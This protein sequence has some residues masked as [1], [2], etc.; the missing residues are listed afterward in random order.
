MR[1]RPVATRRLLLLP[2]RAGLPRAGRRRRPRA[3]P[4]RGPR[5]PRCAPA[6]AR[7]RPDPAARRGG[8][9]G[10]A[11]L[12]RRLDAAETH[13]CADGEPFA[14]ARDAR[15]L[16]ELRDI[17]PLTLHDDQTLAPHEEVL[18]EDGGAYRT[19]S[20]YA[21]AAA[22]CAIPAPAAVRLEG[23]RARPD[24]RT[25]RAAGDRPAIRPSAVRRTPACGA[26]RRRHVGRTRSC[27]WRRAFST[28]RSAR[29]ACL[30]ARRTD[31]GA[32]AHGAVGAVHEVAE[33]EQP[34]LDV[35]QIDASARSR[36]RRRR[37]TSR[38]CTDRRPR[39]RLRARAARR[40][41]PRR[42][43][44]RRTHR[45][46]RHRPRRSDAD[47]P[48][49]GTRRT[50]RRGR[51][52]RHRPGPDS[53]TAGHT[54]HASPITVAVRVA[55]RGR[56]LAAVVSDDARIAVDRVVEDPRRVGAVGH[57]FVTA[58]ASDRRSPGESR[59]RP[60]GRR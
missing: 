2:R 8:R 54:S 10:R 13:A 3:L 34:A 35:R 23:R 30:S 33:L 11:R 24:H 21:R 37:C 56:A 42:P 43:D 47:R 7:R 6:R 57:W 46:R 1:P 58:I 32:P 31:G 51:R 19:Y 22:R 49:P 5:R 55:A 28:R 39:T 4:A 9:G 45:R 20:A 16:R 29:P 14:L 48:P 53:P 52:R 12:A 27:S 38:P 50:R 15:A 41:G 25:S 59:P 36:S 26:R 60:A 40:R 44:T 18:R 17:A